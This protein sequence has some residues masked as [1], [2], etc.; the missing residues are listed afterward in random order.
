MKTM[1]AAHFKARCLKIMD[2]VET[3][4]EPVTIT[5]NGRPVAKLVPADGKP[6]DIFDCLKGE[7]EITGDLVAPVVAPED[8]EALR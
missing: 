7:I 1:A 5:K 8:W 4:R 3:T 2:Q 6:T